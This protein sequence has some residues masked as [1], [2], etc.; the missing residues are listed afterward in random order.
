MIKQLIEGPRWLGTL[1]ACT[2]AVFLLPFAVI[3]CLNLQSDDLAAK[4]LTLKPVYPRQLKRIREDA[5]FTTGIF[6]RDLEVFAPAQDR[7]LV[8]VPPGPAREKLMSAESKMRPL[9]EAW[10][11]G[12]PVD[13][14]RLNKVIE[15]LKEA[16]KLA[17]QNRTAVDYH[18]GL[19]YLLKG[20]Y[21]QAIRYFDN[22][23]A[24][25]DTRAGV[26]SPRLTAVKIVALYAKGHALYEGGRKKDSA[27]RA[28][29]EF[30]AARDLAMAN[31]ALLTGQRPSGPVGQFDDP[32]IRLEGKD[33]GY[34][35]FNT[36]KTLVSLDVSSIAADLAAAE[37]QAVGPE[38][39]SSLDSD[40]PVEA[41]D[42]PELAVNLQI[43]AAL[44]NDGAAVM[45]LPSPTGGRFGEI[46]DRARRITGVAPV[47]DGQLDPWALSK[48]LREHFAR[49]DVGAIHALLDDPDLKANEHRQDR[50]Y[51]KQW[52]NEV[53]AAA[54]NDARAQDRSERRRIERDYRQVYSVPGSIQIAGVDIPPFVWGA[55]VAWFVLTTILALFL[56]R[57]RAI[58]H[59]F[60]LPP[61][62]APALASNPGAIS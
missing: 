45:R 24:L 7:G 1:A 35:R 5:A 53:I 15:Q 4:P 12:R 59:R 29:G 16:D 33:A 48:D 39:I 62:T 51:L 13:T 50:L 49:G 2:A 55:I 41:G 25:V 10:R 18:V 27:E 20:D 61:I 30:K 31:R 42:R 8:N 43:A 14:S 32:A 54:L 57:A 52:V 56:H 22:V 26:Q 28:A 36:E 44:V 17:G 60:Y 58:Y 34:F 3:F 23:V 46:S 21:T 38:R 40:I 47:D 19:A 6:V 11:Q 9:L 37:I